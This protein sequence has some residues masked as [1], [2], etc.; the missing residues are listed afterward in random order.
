MK[1]LC[2]VCKERITLGRRDSE[3]LSG[4]LICECFK[5]RS[6]F[7]FIISPHRVYSP[8]LIPDDTPRNIEIVLHAYESTERAR[9]RA[10]EVLSAST[11]NRTAVTDNDGET[12][13]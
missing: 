8:H 7:S 12:E 13:S 1:G 9:A 11:D 4:V 3:P 2:P 5:C 10:G 6:W